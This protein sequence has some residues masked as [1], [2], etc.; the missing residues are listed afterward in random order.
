[1]PYANIRSLALAVKAMRA[2]ERYGGGHMMERSFAGFAQ[3]PPPEGE[4]TIPRRPWREVLGR[5]G[6]AGPNFAQLAG[7]EASCKT[8]RLSGASRRAWRQPR[9][10]GRT[11]HCGRTGERGIAIMSGQVV[12]PPA[13]FSE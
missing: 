5:I 12:A 7:A 6:M 10:R 3:L 8:A 4:S 11:Q 1:M 9:S 2:I 13:P